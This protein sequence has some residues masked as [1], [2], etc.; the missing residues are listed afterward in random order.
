MS[1]PAPTRVPPRVDPSARAL[2]CHAE[3]TAGHDP[4]GA[5]KSTTPKEAT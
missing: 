2:T 4:P 5:T 3:A 1:R